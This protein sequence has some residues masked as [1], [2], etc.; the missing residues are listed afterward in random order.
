MLDRIEIRLEKEQKCFVTSDTHAQHKNIVR[1]ET[2]WDM[3]R[4]NNSVRDFNTRDEMDTVMCNNT[5]EVVMPDDWLIHL[6]DWSFGGIEQIWEFRKRLNVKN[7]L[8]V[9]GNH[10]HH[11]YPKSK[12]IYI[13]NHD[14]AV[15]QQLGIPVYRTEHKNILYVNT[16]ELFTYVTVN[17]WVKVIYPNMSFNFD[18]FHRPMVSWEKMSKGWM[19]LYGHLHSKPKDVT[20]L[21]GK[22]MDVGIDGN[23]MKPWNL[24]DVIKRLQKREI[25]SFFRDDHHLKNV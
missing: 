23:N 9:R 18:L 11:I 7:I 21:K 2:R 24:M 19:H 14:V 12:P 16:Q 25:D 20:N 17:P 10:D 6:G 22:C 4:A 1:G 15:A 3:D 8:F 13:D 5:N